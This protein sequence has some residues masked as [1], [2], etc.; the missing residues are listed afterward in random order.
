MRKLSPVVFS[1]VSLIL[2]Y[3]FLTLLT[4]CLGPKKIDKWVAEKYFELPPP[5]KKKH[6]QILISSSQTFAGTQLSSTV[7]KTSNMVPLIV[8]WQFDYKNTCTL[9]PVI[10]ENI[11]T[12]TV[13]SYGSHG[14]QQKLNGQRIELTIRKIPTKF[15]IDDKG[16]L[17]FLIYAYSWDYLTIL[18]EER[19]FTVSYK[20]FDTHNQQT[21]TGEVT[22]T[23]SDKA[24]DV[25][26]FQSLK[27]KTWAFLDQYDAGIAVMSKHVVDKIVAE[28]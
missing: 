23:G 7:K 28:L 10:A 1:S 3:C 13:L 2:F 14:M 27:K 24:I 17:I 5:P 15:A 6:D 16:H 11:F 18:P 21:K 20:V 9:N 26:M 12:T 25:H 22:L 19:D 8:Y 4:S